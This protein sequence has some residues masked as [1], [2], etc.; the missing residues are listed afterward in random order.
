MPGFTRQKVLAT[1][2]RLL[3]VSLI[4]VGNEEYERENDSFGLTTL[5][6]RHVDVHGSAICFHFRG[7]GG[8]QH[9]IDVRDRRLAQI[10]RKCQDLPGKD[11]FQYVDESNKLQDVKS[12]DVNGYL[13]EITGED[14]TAKDFRTWSGTVLAA[15]ALQEFKIIT[16]KTQARKN[17]VRAIE[18][19]A[20]RL[21]NTP[22]VCKKCYVHPQV[23]EGYLD[24]T[25]ATAL[26]RWARRS[27]R[28]WRHLRPEE[29]AVLALLQRRVARQEQEKKDPFA[30]WKAEMRRRG[31]AATR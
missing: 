7:K 15:L 21:G 8:K 22:S 6:N 13:R 16:S 27:P 14:F 23:L 19:V 18:S 2:V 30:S 10:L 12:T 31:A 5:K 4:R 17:I 11:L 1:V 20:S 3:E 25:L 9:R 29:A 24:G 26:E 28:R